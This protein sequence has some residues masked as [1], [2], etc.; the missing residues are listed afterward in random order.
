MNPFLQKSSRL[1]LFAFLFTGMAFSQ[2][3]DTTAA[4]RTQEKP[5]LSKRIDFF[6][7]GAIESGEIESGHYGGNLYAEI[8]HL[9][10]GHVFADLGVAATANKYLSTLISVEARIWYNTSPLSAVR[11][12]TT[13]GAAMQNCNIIITNAEGI[14]SFG[15]HKNVF[16]LTLSLGRFEYKY[17]PQAQDLG[18][19]LFRTGCYPA[20]I[21]TSFDLPLAR[22]NGCLL[23]VKLFDCFRQDLLLTTMSDID[24]FYNFSLTYLADVSVGKVFD[25]GVGVS[26]CNL[27]SVDQTN[28][29]ATSTHDYLTNGYLKAPGDTGYYTFQGTKLMARF[30]FDPKRFFNAPIFGETD[31]QIY[32]E[33]AVLGVENYPRSN[34]IDTTNTCNVYGYDNFWQKVPVMLGVNVPTCRLLD[35]LSVEGEWFGSR[36]PDSYLS[37]TG[38]VAAVPTPPGPNETDYDYLHDDWKWVVYAKKTILGRL[39]FIGLVGRDH[40]RTE[41][42]IEK[43]QDYEETLIKNS[44]WYWMLKIKYGF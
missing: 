21:E 28:D 22:L 7:S 4:A 23:S 39:S 19:Y 34:A 17:N 11:D 9:W 44:H 5:S 38:E 3:N 30:M 15:D 29:M 27:I 14:L 43:Y 25:A 16:D 1:V 40:L 6:G 41:T 35:V 37:Y 26:F 42:Y 24:P 20:Y 32:A 33:A 2:T 12:N 31:G 10:M 18:E 13:F 8:N 36:Y